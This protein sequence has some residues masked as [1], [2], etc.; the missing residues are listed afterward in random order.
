MIGSSGTFGSTAV[1]IV[2]PYCVQSTPRYLFRVSCAST[3]R[4]SYFISEKLNFLLIYEQL[5]FLI[6]ANLMCDIESTILSYPV[7]ILNKIS[8]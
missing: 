1:L 3:P 4:A 7:R 5:V 6:S 8:K 2:W